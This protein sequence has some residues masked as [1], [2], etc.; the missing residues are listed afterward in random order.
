MIAG[1]RRRLGARRVHRIRSGPAAGLRMGDRWAWSG[2]YRSGE[3]ERPVQEWF[4]E[5]VGP[6]DVVLDVGANAGFFSVLAA[7]RCGPGGRV[8]A[9]EP[10]PELCRVVERNAARNG[11]SIEVHPIAASDAAGV[12]EF[13][14]GA[15]P[16]GGALAKS[17]SAPADEE[18]RHFDVECATIDDVVAAAGLTRIDAVK[19]DVEGTESAVIRG[20]RATLVAHRPRLLVE[21]DSLDAEGLRVRHDEVVAQLSELGYDCTLL[22]DSYPGL[23]WRVRHIAAS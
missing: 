1:L 4:V 17:P 11:F 22:E 16:G 9:F 21:I 12:E 3:N 7:S 19:I 5:A 18:L 20:A 15:H 13:V 14:L 2:D 10:V 6:D 23:D 8:H